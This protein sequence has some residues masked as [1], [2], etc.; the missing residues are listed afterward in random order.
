MM[1]GIVL[2]VVIAVLALPLAAF[3]WGVLCAVF[4]DPFKR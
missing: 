3:A 2:G 1:A 4:V